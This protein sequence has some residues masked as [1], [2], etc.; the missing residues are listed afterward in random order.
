MANCP[1]KRL[2]VQTSLIM[3]V[4][5]KL[6]PALFVSLM[7]AGCNGALEQTI[8]HSVVGIGHGGVTYMH[9]Q[10]SP[11]LLAGVDKVYERGGFLHPIRT[12]SGALLSDSFPEDHRHHHGIWTAWSAV[13]WNGIRPDFWN[14]GNAT[15]GVRTVSEPEWS[16]DRSE[17]V[18]R[19]ESYAETAQGR[20]TLLKETWK[21]RPLPGLPRAHRFDLEISQLNV[22]EHP[23]QLG[24]HHY[25]GLGLR[26][27][28]DWVHTRPEAKQLVFLT[29]NGTRDRIKGDGEACRWFYFGGPGPSGQVGYVVMN[30]SYGPDQHTR[31]NPKDPFV[32]YTPVK[33]EGLSISPKATLTMRY[34]ILLLDGPPD[35][36]AI[37]AEWR[38]AKG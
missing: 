38:A 27:R 1:I 34:R 30:L 24:T 16:E 17:L 28:S 19:M 36:D 4:C 25:G 14:V 32:A 6:L 31:F 18:C 35:V 8:S 11:A 9:Y 2:N 15:G 21:V 20:L 23:V 37:E 7:L 3:K 5:M 29:S 13:D 26:G 22:S 12:P 10:H 33:L